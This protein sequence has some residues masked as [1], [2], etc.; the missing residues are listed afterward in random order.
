MLIPAVFFCTYTFILYATEDDTVKSTNGYARP[1]VDG[2]RPEMQ[3]FEEDSCAIDDATT[4]ESLRPTQ[5]L[6]KEMIAALKP[7]IDKNVPEKVD[8]KNVVYTE[9]Q[10]PDRTL[11]V[12]LFRLKVTQ[13]PNKYDDGFNRYFLDFAG[14]PKG[15]PYFCEYCIAS[16]TKQEILEKLNLDTLPE[17]LIGLMPKIAYDLNDI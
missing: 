6:M 16:G 11:D 8:Y 14:Y 15:N 7:K 5:Q 1:E 3:L 9:F 13:N 10:N 4:E 12:A 2:V 17:R